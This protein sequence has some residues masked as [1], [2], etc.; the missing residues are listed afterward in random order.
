[1]Q[2]ERARD[3]LVKVGNGS[4]VSLRREKG[5][6]KPGFQI[7]ELGQ[8][9]AQLLHLVNVYALSDE[10]DKKRI[11]EE[12]HKFSKRI[13]LSSKSFMRGYRAWAG[14]LPHAA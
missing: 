5:K 9:T 3:Q 8:V 12:I 2:L 4:S 7:N 13:T 1:M 6:G 11:L 10:T 14:S